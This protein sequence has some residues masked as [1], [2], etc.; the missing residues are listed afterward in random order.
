MFFFSISLWHIFSCFKNKLNQFDSIYFIKS[1]LSIWLWKRILFPLWFKF[2]FLPPFTDFQSLNHVA[3][4]VDVC[5][6]K[7]DNLMA[8]RFRDYSKHSLVHIVVCHDFTQHY[9][10]PGSWRS[11]A[12]QQSLSQSKVTFYRLYSAAIKTYCSR[13][14]S[15]YLKTLIYLSWVPFIDQR[16]GVTLCRDHIFFFLF[17]QDGFQLRLPRLLSLVV[18]SIPC[19]PQVDLS[20]P[21]VR[22]LHHGARHQYESRKVIKRVINSIKTCINS[23]THSHTYT[24]W[25]ES[26]SAVLKLKQGYGIY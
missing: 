25:M 8:W 2:F 17:L 26:R 1:C 3:S 24:L 15:N 23:F 18:L 7:Q 22:T 16:P 10:V 4:Q 5:T 9:Y 14:W 21:C 13:T 6:G 12:P 11:K 20:F 19:I